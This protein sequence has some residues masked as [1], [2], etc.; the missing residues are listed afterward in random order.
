M[1]YR[2]HILV[3]LVSIVVSLVSLNTVQAC[4]DPTDTYSVE[5]VFNKPGVSYNLS[6]LENISNI[7]PIG[8]RAYVYRAHLNSSFIVLLTKTRLY[9]SE[10]YLSIRIEPD[11]NVIPKKTYYVVNINSSI[12]DSI[13]NIVSRV[14]NILLEYEWTRECCIIK[15]ASLDKNTGET[16]VAGSC[17]YYKFIKKYR[18]ELV[19]DLWRVTGVNKTI[20]TL[21]FKTVVP[22]DSNSIS[23]EINDTITRIL[24]RTI[25][26]GYT[27]IEENSYEIP[28]SYIETI[29]SILTYE[30]QWLISIDVLKGLNDSDLEAIESIAKPGLAGWNSRIVYDMLGRWIS[31]KDAQLPVKATL[32][33]GGCSVYYSLEDVPDNPPPSYGFVG[34]AAGTALVEAA[35]RE[36]ASDTT[37]ESTTSGYPVES[38]VQQGGR[39]G[40]RVENVLY[41]LLIALTVSFIV[42]F[43][44]KR[45]M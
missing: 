37:L 9:G 42:W 10:E 5:V 43:I 39:E 29:K 28:E 40:N 24:G 41:P 32:T 14:D 18:V 12:D 1:M 26:W 36:T 20:V 16:P 2:L 15:N 30:I 8:D 7:S 33:G 3:V 23:D 11:P 6:V 25:E 22:I 19:I 31:Y 45:Y 17:S 34:S 38:Q 35:S 13:E 4:L 21:Q 27:V 44:L